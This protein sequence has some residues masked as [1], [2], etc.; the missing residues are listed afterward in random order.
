MHVHCKDVRRTVLDTALGSRQSFLDAVLID[1][2][3]M[4]SVR[5]ANIAAY[6]RAE[7]RSVADLEARTPAVEA[8]FRAEPKVVMGREAGKSP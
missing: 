2:G 7:L 5:A 6:P 3:F 4:G 8:G 1:A